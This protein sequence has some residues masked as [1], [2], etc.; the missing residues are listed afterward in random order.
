MKTQDLITIV[1]SLHV[2]S[3]NIFDF[4]LYIIGKIMDSSV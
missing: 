4:L 3:I 2:L 1:I